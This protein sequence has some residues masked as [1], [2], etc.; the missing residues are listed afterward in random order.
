M[1]VE[2]DLET[3]EMLE[4]AGWVVVR[5]WEHEEAAHAAKRIAE[6]VNRRR[7]YYLTRTVTGP[8]G[9]EMPR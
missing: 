5:V 2:R 3:T 9:K 1:N 6:A 7:E 4:A 8:D